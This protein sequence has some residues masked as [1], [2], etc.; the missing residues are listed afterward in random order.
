MPYYLG[1][2]LREER[3]NNLPRSRTSLIGS[4]ARGVCARSREGNDKD[5]LPKS[6]QGKTLS[7]RVSMARP[8]YLS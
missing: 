3:V 2:A 8:C 6:A 5:E 7:V 4:L 1:K